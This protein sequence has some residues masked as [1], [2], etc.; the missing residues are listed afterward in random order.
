[1]N[2]LLEEIQI[3]YRGTGFRGPTEEPYTAE[4]LL[5]YF[6]RVEQAK[7]PKELNGG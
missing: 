4:D 1:M 6:W 3:K 5:D 2:R 7:E